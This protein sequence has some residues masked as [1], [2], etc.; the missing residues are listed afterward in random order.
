MTR[1]IMGTLAVLAGAG[2]GGADAQRAHIGL[3]GAYHL[4]LDRAA[5]GA[6]MHIPLSRSLELYPS[7]DYYFVDSG[8]LLGFNGDLKFRAPGGPLY[9]GGGVNLLRRGNGTART[10]TGLNLFGGFESRYGQ[11]HPYVELR[12]LVHDETALQLAFGINITLR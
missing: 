8:T 9:L 2:L 1:R 4:D 7:F 5:I 3:H 12:A 6:Q 10:D 11:T